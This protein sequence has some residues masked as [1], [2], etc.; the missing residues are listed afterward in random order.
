MKLK[1]SYILLVVTNRVQFSNDRKCVCVYYF[2]GAMFLAE[3]LA[4]D[5]LGV[6]L[7]IEIFSISLNLFFVDLKCAQ[8]VM[9]YIV[10]VYE[11]FRVS[12]IIKK[13]VCLFVLI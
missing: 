11:L 7:I 6:S 9:L 2:H 3:E 8:C 10:Y 5:T 13:F 12:L 1:L 4:R